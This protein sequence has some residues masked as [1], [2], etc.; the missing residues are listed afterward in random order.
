MSAATV[1]CEFARFPDE[2]FQWAEQVFTAYTENCTL[3][4]PSTPMDWN[5]HTKNAEA[6]TMT[7]LYGTLIEEMQ[8]MVYRSKTNSGIFRLPENKSTPETIICI[9]TIL[10][11]INPGGARI[12][13]ELGNYLRSPKE[14]DTHSEALAEMAKW[15]KGTCKFRGQRVSTRHTV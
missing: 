14:A 7:Y 11:H 1:T 9:A 2:M 12:K 13:R 3:E 10:N 5:A 4:F 15:K 8:S 6:T